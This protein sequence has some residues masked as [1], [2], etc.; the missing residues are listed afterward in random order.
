MYSL[1]HHSGMLP[2]AIRRLPV[3]I[4]SVYDIFDFSN[5]YYV[6]QDPC[7]NQLPNLPFA[8]PGNRVQWGRGLEKVFGW[9]WH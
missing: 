5:P 2:P 8:C 6:S 4:C 1:H 3:A 9:S 7:H